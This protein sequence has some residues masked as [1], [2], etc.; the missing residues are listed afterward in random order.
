MVFAARGA[1]ESAPE[2]MG[3]GLFNTLERDAK[4]KADILHAKIICHERGVQVK[5]KGDELYV[6]LGQAVI[7]L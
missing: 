5:R 2:K 3:N 1:E 4:V 6:N 7:G